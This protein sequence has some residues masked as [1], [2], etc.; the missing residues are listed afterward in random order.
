MR[1]MS[2]A[3]TTEQVRNRT[4]DVTRRFGWWFLKPG[5]V[6]QPVIKGM[7]LKKGEK[8]KKIGGPIR[9]VST[10]REQLHHMECGECVREGFPEMNESEFVSMLMKHYRC[11]PSSYVNRI[12]FE[13]LHNDDVSVP[14]KRSERGFWMSDKQPPWDKG[15]DGWDNYTDFLSWLRKE[16]NDDDYDDWIDESPPILMMVFY[17]LWS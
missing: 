13:Y 5:D 12:E 14:M 15:R 1:N 7:G 11:N 8:I 6:V 9:I 3:M 10:R 17:R 4:K 16:I 2:F